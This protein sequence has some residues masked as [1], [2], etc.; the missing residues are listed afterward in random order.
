M[1][2]QAASGSSPLWRP[3]ALCGASFAP[4]GARARTRRYCSPA[5]A[6]RAAVIAYQSR[7]REAGL[8]RGCGAELALESRAYCSRCL[9]A[10]R[11]R[12]RASAGCRPW[13][14]NGRGRPPMSR[15]VTVVAGHSPSGGSPGGPG[16]SA[17]VRG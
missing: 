5:C 15:A 1:V 17:E 2:D 6:H 14:E 10:M 7:K 3:C 9:L 13:R 12:N 8:C 4:E 11:V 16:D